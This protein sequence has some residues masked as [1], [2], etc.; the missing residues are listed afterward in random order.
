MGPAEAVS[1]L[2]RRCGFRLGLVEPPANCPAVR[3]LSPMDVC[4]RCSASGRCLPLVTDGTVTAVARV[5]MRGWRHDRE[6]LEALCTLAGAAL[7]GAHEIGDLAN[8]ALTDP[9][10]GLPNRRGMERELSRGTYR[11]MFGVL[12]CDIDHFKAVNDNHGHDAGDAVLVAFAGC[13]RANVRH[14]DTV[15]RWGG[16]EFVVLLPGMGREELGEV[17]ERL[18][19][20]VEELR[21]SAWPE[22]LRITASFGGA[23]YPL[24]GSDIGALI[25]AADAALY[26][27]KEGGRNQCRL[28]GQ[29]GPCLSGRAMCGGAGRAVHQ[30][31]QSGKW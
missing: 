31:A 6:A 16:E 25:A 9:L 22:G 5:R 23:V 21:D 3:E 12:L 26:R 13:L 15:A 1:I 7:L 18:R 4:R 27:A 14:C 28:A 10:T 2:A 11:G 8:R 29:R 20:A 17:G 24:D 19:R 30:P